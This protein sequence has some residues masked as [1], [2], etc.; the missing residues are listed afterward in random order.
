MWPSVSISR[1]AVCRSSHLVV[2]VLVN[3]NTQHNL[4]LE[5]AIELALDKLLWRLLAARGA[6]HWWCMPNDDDVLIGQ[7]G[8]Y[9]A[10]VSTLCIHSLA[11]DDWERWNICMPDTPPGVGWWKQSQYRTGWDIF[12]RLFIHSLFTVPQLWLEFVVWG[13]HLWI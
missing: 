8:C 4:T 7:A 3:L 10:L 5:D 13:M 9:Q 1:K 2:L 12:W 11:D 6:M